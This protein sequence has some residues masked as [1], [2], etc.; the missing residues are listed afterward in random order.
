MAVLTGLTSGDQTV[1]FHSRRNR[2]WVAVHHDLEELPSA[3]RFAR[4]PSC[5]TWRHVAFHALQLRVRRVL[6]CYKLRRHDVTRLSAELRCFHVLY[7]PICELCSDNY[8]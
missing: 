8:I 4:D 6:V 1:G 5:R 3:G 2:S 7:G